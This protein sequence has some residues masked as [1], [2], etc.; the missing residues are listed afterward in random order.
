[1]Q[2][3]FPIKIE[4]SEL[5]SIKDY[6]KKN[7]LS[8]AEVFRNG[9]LSLIS[10]TPVLVDTTELEALR[11]QVKALTEENNAQRDTLEANAKEDNSISHVTITGRE[12]PNFG[13]PTKALNQCAANIIYRLARV[14]AGSADH[15]CRITNSWASSALRITTSKFV[16]NAPS[17]D[18]LSVMEKSASKG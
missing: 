3:S 15:Y 5:D 4:G 8:A 17:K 9:A 7:N 11:A 2:T 1:M 10:S 12:I 6:A 18:E 13:L 16:P 14:P